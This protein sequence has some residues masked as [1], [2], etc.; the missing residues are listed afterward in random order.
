[1]KIVNLGCG[2][3]FKTSSEW[4]NIDMHSDSP[5]VQKHNFLK[6]IPI[7]DNAVDAVYHSHILEH[8]AKNDG[9]NF[10][11][12]CHRVLKKDGIIRIATPNL[13]VIAQ[14][15]LENLQKAMNNIPGAEN[16]YDWILLEM[17]DQTVRNHSGGEMANYLFQN[18]LPNENYVFS[19]IGDEGRKWREDY[20][21]ESKRKEKGINFKEYVIKNVKKI[22]K[23]VNPIAGNKYYQV[24]KFRF[25]GEVHLWMYDRFSLSRMLNN[26]GFYDFAVQTATTSYIPGWKDYQLDSNTGSAS[27]FAEA[28]KK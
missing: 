24:G 21:A 4:I 20:L 15:Y 14:Q 8:F 5:Y 6:G 17:Y 28:R 27:I 2:P 23:A 1:M 3:K 19:R 10:I 25:G 22:T 18:D 16:D 26:I 13:E 9:Y 12:E 11:K 7:E